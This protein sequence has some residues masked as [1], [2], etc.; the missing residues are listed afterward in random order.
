MKAK[1]I[2]CGSVGSDE[3]MVGMISERMAEDSNKVLDKL[4]RTVAQAEALD[5]MLNGRGVNLHKVIEIQ[6]NEEAL[7]ARIERGLRKPERLEVMTMH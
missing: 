4:L 7:F 3:I 1:Q 2:R 6:V 5:A